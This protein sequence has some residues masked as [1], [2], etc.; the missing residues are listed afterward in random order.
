L[1]WIFYIFLLIIFIEWQNL[2]IILFG[3]L[4]KKR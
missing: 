3:F 1:I 4:K 2:E